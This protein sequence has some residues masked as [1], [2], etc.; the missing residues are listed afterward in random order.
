MEVRVLGPVQAIDGDHVIEIGPKERVL[1][2]RIA[3]ARGRSVTDSVLVDVLWGDR[4]PPAARKT[5]QGYVHR[6]RRALG[7]GAIIRADAGYRLSP[8]VDLDLDLVDAAMADSRHAVA[9]GRLDEAAVLFRTSPCSIPRR[10]ASGIGGR[11]GERRTQATT[12]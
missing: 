11:S 2:A 9:D 5:L 4:P 10:G 3:A 7:D 12:R 1:L 8:T 6:L